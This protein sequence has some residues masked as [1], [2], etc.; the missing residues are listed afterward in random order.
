MSNTA[1]A[2]AGTRNMEF[3]L[4]CLRIA[5]NSA[6]SQDRDGEQVSRR[7]VFSPL[8]FPFSGTNSAYSRVFLPFAG[9]FLVIS[10]A[11]FVFAG[12]IRRLRGGF[13]RFHNSGVLYHDTS[14]LCDYKKIVSE[15]AP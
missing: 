5:K 14:S 7:T 13:C 2:A 6:D 3:W 11:F 8:N 12:R 15:A 10:G 9:R 4:C 1:S